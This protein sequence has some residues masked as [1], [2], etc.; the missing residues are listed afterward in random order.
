[1]G[2]P[3]TGLV[4]SFLL[5]QRPIPDDG[6]RCGLLLLLLLSGSL[7]MAGGVGKAHLSINKQ[8]IQII[9]LPGEGGGVQIDRF[10]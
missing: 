1:L 5:D 6:E 4:L 8:K 9:D 3:S 2:L 10:W 7:R